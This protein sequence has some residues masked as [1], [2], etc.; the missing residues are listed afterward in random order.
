MNGYNYASCAPN[1]GIIYVTWWQNDATLRL[2]YKRSNSISYTVNLYQETLTSAQGRYGT[3]NPPSE[4][5]SSGS[6]TPDP[7]DGR[8]GEEIDLSFLK[9]YYDEQGFS[10]YENGV[11]PYKS[12]FKI[13]VDADESKNVAD[14]YYIRQDN[15]SFQVQ[16]FQQGL[17]GNYPTLPT[18]TKSYSAIFGLP[19]YTDAVTGEH[20]TQPTGISPANDFRVR[21]DFYGF[22]FDP[23]KSDPTPTATIGYGT[24]IKLYYARNTDIVWKVQFY[25]QGIIQST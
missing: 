2:Y 20:A 8:L 23:S 11:D 15:V 6:Y 25:T 16:Y 18:D 12:K 10:V 17:D 22:T 19:V 4:F 13:V 5:V 14:I 21:N 9:S 1:N 7:P 3:P 24:V